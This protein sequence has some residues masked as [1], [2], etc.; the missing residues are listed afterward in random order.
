MYVYLSL[1]FCLFLSLP[2]YVSLFIPY[3]SLILRQDTKDTKDKT[4][5]NLQIHLKDQLANHWVHFQVNGAKWYLGKGTEY[6]WDE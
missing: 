4:N 1:C 6:S 5:G 2:I 3:T